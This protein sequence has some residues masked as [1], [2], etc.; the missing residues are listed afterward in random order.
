MKHYCDEFQF[1]KIIFEV[2]LAERS[3]SFKAVRK[4]FRLRNA[5]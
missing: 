1:F 3:Y 4:L 5:A 2:H